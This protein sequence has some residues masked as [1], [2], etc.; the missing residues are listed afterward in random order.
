MLA[1]W[2]ESLLRRLVH[3]QDLVAADKEACVGLFLIVCCAVMHHSLRES[4]ISLDLLTVPV[5]LGEIQWTEV[6]VVADIG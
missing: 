1:E 6:L 2:T 3:E 5:D 4:N